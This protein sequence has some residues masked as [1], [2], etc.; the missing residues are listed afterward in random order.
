MYEI[1]QA[2]IGRITVEESNGNVTVCFKPEPSFKWMMGADTTCT[3]AATPEPDGS[4]EATFAEGYAVEGKIDKANK[5]VTGRLI[6]PEAVV[7]WTAAPETYWQM[8]MSKGPMIAKSGLAIY[9]G[10]TLGRMVWDRAMKM[11]MMKRR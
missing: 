8:V 1:K 4:F 9:G 3:A 5:T 7:E 2:G 11:K 6:S 10:Y